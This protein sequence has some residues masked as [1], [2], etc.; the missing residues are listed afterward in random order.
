MKN[1]L[2]ILDN[3]ITKQN[4]KMK[5]QNMKNMKMMNAMRMKLFCLATFAMAMTAAHLTAQVFTTLHTFTGGSDGSNP[6]G[7]LILSGN[8]LYGA[9]DTGT[10]YGYGTVFK[11]NTDGTAFK[12]LETF[13]GVN[14]EAYPSYL[15]LSGNT[16][17]GP[18]GG[19]GT[20]SG[21][22]FAVNTNGTGFTTLHTFNTISA[23]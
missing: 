17:Y 23:P 7:S 19:Q 4:T 6:F 20:T 5:G 10:S 9:A 1:Q 12:V 11:V 2:T 13:N 16:L 8:T 14:N 15:L 18:S 3:G 22:L 21:A